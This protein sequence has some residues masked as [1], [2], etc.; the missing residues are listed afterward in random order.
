MILVRN[1]DLELTNHSKAFG[2]QLHFFQAKKEKKGYVFQNTTKFALSILLLSLFCYSEILSQKISSCKTDHISY[3]EK[4]SSIVA[5]SNRSNNVELQE[6]TFWQRRV[7]ENT[8]AKEIVI[9]IPVVVHVIH[10]DPSSSPNPTMSSHISVEQVISQIKVLNEDF[11]KQKNSNGFNDNPIG[12]DIGIEF[13]LASTDPNGQNSAGINYIY[14]SSASW[15]TS[16]EDEKELK[17]LSYWPSDKYLNIWVTNLEVEKGFGYARYPYG[18]GIE[19]LET[20]T[21]YGAEL[22]GIVIDHR[23]FGT[24]GTV[25]TPYNLGR[26]ATHEV[27]HWLGLKH[28]WGDEYCGNDFVDDTPVDQSPN[29]D[30]DCADSSYCYDGFVKDITS[31]YLDFSPDRCMNHFTTG[32]KERMLRSLLNSPRRRGLFSSQG[33]SN[34]LQKLYVNTFPNPCSEFLNIDLYWP[35]NQSIQLDWYNCQGSIIFSKVLET[36]KAQTFQI[37]ISSWSEGIYIL[38]IKNTNNNDSES[39]KYTKIL[40]QH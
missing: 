38:K 19:D 22:D 25:V 35:G 37:D 12:A 30:L 33:C 11:R 29:S 40:V 39:K 16:T 28:I 26:T 2:S 23:V 31:N 9:R 27:G 5:N 8:N 32:Q 21:D 14:N 4:K 17:S 7:A 34:L 6:I 13:C 1:L 18:T 24:I 36:P 20:D 3:S 10:N 15:N